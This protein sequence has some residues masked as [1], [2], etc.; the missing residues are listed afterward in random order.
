MYATYFTIFF[1][2]G[3]IS[4]AIKCETGKGLDNSSESVMLCIH[5]ILTY[6]CNISFAKNVKCEKN[7]ILN[8]NINSL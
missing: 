5:R 4:L 3:N 6:F 8:L 7:M 1:V 2:N